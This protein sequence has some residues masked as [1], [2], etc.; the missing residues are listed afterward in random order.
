MADPASAR[1]E[2][3]RSFDIRIGDRKLEAAW[4]GP[5][6]ASTP[7]IVLLHE[8]LGSVSAW[9]DWPAK[10]A[11]ESK[12]GVLTF[13]RFGYGQS[14]DAILPRP[15]SY[16]HEEAH[17]VLPAVIE[18]TSLRDFV[19]VGHS[20]GGSIAI[21]YAGSEHATPGL[22]GIALMS[23]HVFVEHVSTRS[24]ALAG[25]AFDSSPLKSRL[26]KHHRDV[27]RAFWGW[28]RIWLD[29]NFRSWNIESFVPK[30]RVPMLLIQEKDDPYGAL[31]Q[32]EAIE[33]ES[34]AITKLLILPGNGHAPW[35]DEQERTTR[36]IIDF[37]H[38]VLR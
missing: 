24:I 16:M 15:V 21:L 11:E 1:Y 6:P 22:K 10:L 12:L 7:T 32:I 28:N 2:P 33:H 5:G 3:A 25:D 8:G 20:D 27:E 36:A 34:K 26:A 30:I 35:R 37:A 17:A 31:A 14:D 38:G 23:P 4:Y 19:L 9:R 18:Q 29:P 13:S